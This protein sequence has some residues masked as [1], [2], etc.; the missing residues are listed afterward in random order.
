MTLNV[1]NSLPQSTN[2]VADQRS[3]AAVALLFSGD[4]NPSH[5]EHLG[6]RSGVEVPVVEVRSQGRESRT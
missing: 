4:V 1:I 6:L 2:V 5:T 3:N